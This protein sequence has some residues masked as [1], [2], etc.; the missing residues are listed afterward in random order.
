MTISLEIRIHSTY[1]NLCRSGRTQHSLVA[2]KNCLDRV[3]T[4]GEFPLP[5]DAPQ[6]ES[7]QSGIDAIL[8]SLHDDLDTVKE[9]LEIDKM[10]KNEDSFWERALY[11]FRQSFRDQE[12]REIF[13]RIE[14]YERLL[15][16]HFD[17]CILLV[18]P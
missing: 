7:L 17:M 10:L 4:L 16:T 11:V 3:A 13:Q 1:N 18:I 15:Q 14:K 2:L 8:K 6:N 12:I 9:R 5:V